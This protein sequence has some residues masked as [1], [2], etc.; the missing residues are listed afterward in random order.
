MRYTHNYNISFIKHVILSILIM[1]YYIYYSLA[2]Q[3][4]YIQLY[5]NSLPVSYNIIAT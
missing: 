3:N 2:Q 5:N 1:T 4:I